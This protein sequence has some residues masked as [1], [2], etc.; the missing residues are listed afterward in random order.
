MDGIDQNSGMI[1]NLLSNLITGNFGVGDAGYLL[2]RSDQGWA[3]L[4]NQSL[5][6]GDQGIR[7]ACAGTS[8][9]AK[10]VTRIKSLIDLSLSLLCSDECGIL[11][12]FS[13]IASSLAGASTFCVGGGGGA[14]SHAKPSWI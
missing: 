8:F 4:R 6:R 1:L 2:P 13:H 9:K 14:E 5:Q 12:R 7:L 11:V 3:S 10:A